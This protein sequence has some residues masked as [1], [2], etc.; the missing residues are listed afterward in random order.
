MVALRHA[1]CSRA[2]GALRAYL[3]PFG[4]A[5]AW[6]AP[7]PCLTNTTSRWCRWLPS[8]D[9]RLLLLVPA[10]L[11]ASILWAACQCLEATDDGDYKIVVAHAGGR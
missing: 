2:A 8:V 7:L 10:L 11:S 4:P 3:G 6:C 5:R 1:Y 9:A